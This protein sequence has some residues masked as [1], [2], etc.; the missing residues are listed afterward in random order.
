MA[1]EEA[2]LPQ[3]TRRLSRVDREGGAAMQGFAPCLIVHL[4]LINNN[5]TTCVKVRAEGVILVCSNEGLQWTGK[6]K[7]QVRGKFKGFFFT[8]NSLVNP[9]T[10]LEAILPNS[11]TILLFRTIAQV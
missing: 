4:H 11:V 5:Q 9:L 8:L 10:F 2:L 6:T 1:Q 3:L 7:I